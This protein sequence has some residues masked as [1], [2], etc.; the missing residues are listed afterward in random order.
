MERLWAKKEELNLFLC[1][2]AF[3]C[4]IYVSMH[5]SLFAL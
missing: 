5:G 2:I 3:M 1:E 4:L